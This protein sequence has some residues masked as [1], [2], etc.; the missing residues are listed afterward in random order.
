MML[1]E[2]RQRLLAILGA[3][4]PLEVKVEY[5]EAVFTSYIL[6]LEAR[7]APKSQPWW[8]YTSNRFTW[9]G[10]SVH[11]KDVQIAGKVMKLLSIRGIKNAPVRD[12]NLFF[13][14]KNTFIGPD[15]FA[16]EVYPSIAE[17]RDNS[18]TY[19][20]F[21]IPFPWGFSVIEEEYA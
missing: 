7:T 20:I 1:Y 19:H 12:W 14:A 6:W 21:E 11:V 2:H 3:P 13:E 10:I 17:L 4:V 16:V 8:E 5:L 9:K 18:F 15:K